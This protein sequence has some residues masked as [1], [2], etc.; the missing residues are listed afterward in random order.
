MNKSLFVFFGMAVAASVQAS[1]ISFTD[2]VNPADVFIAKN[3]AVEQY[4]YLHD[5]TDNGFVSATDHITDADLYISM[6]DDGDES[7]EN[8]RISMDNIIAEQSFHVT[9]GTH[10]FEVNTALLQGDG[11]LSVT[12]KAIA[13]DFYFEQSRLE[14]DADRAAAPVPEPGTMA[15]VAFG[16]AGLGLALRRKQA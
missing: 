12:L 13:G 5:I 14:V 4:T 11:K 3:G 2:V 8:V 15:L 16:V 9:T 7:A 10:E 1:P 6:R